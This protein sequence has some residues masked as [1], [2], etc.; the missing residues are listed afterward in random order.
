M[1]VLTVPE[2]HGLE[3]LSVEKTVLFASFREHL[4]VLH[5][6]EGQVSAVDLLDSVRHEL[7]NQPV[8][9]MKDFLPSFPLNGLTTGQLTCTTSDHHVV[10]SRSFPFHHWYRT[11]LR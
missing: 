11:P 6:F 10:G 5:E 8:H 2:V 7:V 3:S 9:K 1:Y 4:Y